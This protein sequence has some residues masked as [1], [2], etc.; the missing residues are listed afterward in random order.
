MLAKGD[1]AQP[2]FRRIKTLIDLMGKWYFRP[3]ALP[4]ILALQLLF[5]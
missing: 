2:S 3:I 1:R 5:K 4:Y